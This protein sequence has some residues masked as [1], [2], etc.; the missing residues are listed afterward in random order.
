MYS[1]RFEG[2]DWLVLGHAADACNNLYL[3]VRDTVTGFER[4]VRADKA[5]P[6]WEVDELDLVIL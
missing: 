4:S 6:G 3:F 5:V 2:R 1:V